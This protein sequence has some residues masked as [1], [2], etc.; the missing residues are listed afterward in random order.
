[1]G[2]SAEERAGFE[3]PELEGS[4]EAEVAVDGDWYAPVVGSVAPRLLVAP[5]FLCLVCCHRYQAGELSVDAH[6]PFSEG[7]VSSE[8]EPELRSACLLSWTEH[9]RSGA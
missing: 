3:W 2:L 5:R 1:M 6:V 4:L 8:A 9:T 7:L